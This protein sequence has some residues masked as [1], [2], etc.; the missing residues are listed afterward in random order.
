VEFKSIEEGTTDKDGKISSANI[1]LNTTRHDK[2][3]HPMNPG[4]YT[5]VITAFSPQGE[6]ILVGRVSFTLLAFK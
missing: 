1:Y 2:S 6:P 3:G 4:L 5:I